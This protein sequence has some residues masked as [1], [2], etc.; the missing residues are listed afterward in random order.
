MQMEQKVC[1]SWQQPPPAAGDEGMEDIL[2][3]IGPAQ[4]SRCRDLSKAVQSLEVMEYTEVEVAGRS[5]RREAAS[6]F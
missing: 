6:I 1:G 2:H 3:R 5:E 4:T